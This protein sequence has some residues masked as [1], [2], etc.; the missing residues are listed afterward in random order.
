VRVLNTVY[1]RRCELAASTAVDVWGIQWAVTG[2][3][4]NV[5]DVG[6]TLPSNPREK[7]GTWSVA[8]ISAPI[9]KPSSSSSSD[10]C[11]QLQ[12]RLRAACVA[13][14]FG[15]IEFVASTINHHRAVRGVYTTLLSCLVCSDISVFIKP[16]LT[17]FNF[18]LRFL[19][20]GVFA[21]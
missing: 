21:S 7:R 3:L 8:L 12:E 17:I 10:Y 4:H 11:V 16:R 14:E 2:I 15:W 5:H 9:Y 13:S 6:E 18:E 19:H 20:L 1:T